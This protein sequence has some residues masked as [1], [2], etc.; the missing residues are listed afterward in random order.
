LQKKKKLLQHKARTVKMHEDRKGNIWLGKTIVN[1]WN[2]SVLFSFC[3]LFF[4]LVV[5]VFS[6]WLSTFILSVGHSVTHRSRWRYNSI[7]TF[8]PSG[9]NSV[10]VNILMTRCRL[11]CWLP[12]T[13][14]SWCRFW[15]RLYRIVIVSVSTVYNFF[16]YRGSQASFISFSVSWLRAIERE[17]ESNCAKFIYVKN[18]SE[19][20]MRRYFWWRIIIIQESVITSNDT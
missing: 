20:V 19:F 14:G 15:H 5:V 10:P 6:I 16:N 11:W 13:S 18:F 9:T 2:E 7:W 3:T 17:R 12:I 4:V 1:E 8:L